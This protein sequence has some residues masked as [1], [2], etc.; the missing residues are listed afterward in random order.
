MKHPIAN[1]S[2]LF[3][4]WEIE[5]SPDQ[6]FPMTESQIRAY[7]YKTSKATSIRAGDFIEILGNVPKNSDEPCKVEAVVYGFYAHSGSDNR[8]MLCLADDGYLLVDPVTQ[9]HQIINITRAGNP[10]PECEP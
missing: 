10:V 9:W 8:M 4:Q 6:C 5:E 2:R 1:P 3:Y 7:K